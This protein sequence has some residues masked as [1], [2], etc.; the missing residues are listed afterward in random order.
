MVVVVFVVGFVVVLVVGAARVFV[1]GAGVGAF[2][3]RDD[4]V[5]FVCVLVMVVVV[6]L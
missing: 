2:G 3:V 6:L 4:V 5:V 1:C